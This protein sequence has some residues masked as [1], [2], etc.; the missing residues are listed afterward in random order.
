VVHTAPPPCEPLTR[1]E[2]ELAL[3]VA[4]GQRN[5]SIGDR[6]GISEGTVKMH[7]HDIYAKLGIEIRTQRATDARVRA[8][9]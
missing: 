9:G 7:R 6:L 8:V 4:T 3:L 2:R 1:R 5:R